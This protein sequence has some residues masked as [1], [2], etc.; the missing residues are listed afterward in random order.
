[1]FENKE[2]QEIKNAYNNQNQTG[3]YMIHLSYNCNLKCPYCYQSTIGKSDKEIDKD[4]IINFI[5]KSVMLENFKN[6]EICYI[7][8]EPL[9]YID[10]V[11]YI[12]KKINET[13]KDRNKSY[14]IITNGTLMNIQN[15]QLLSDIGFYNY[16]ITID[17][18]KE[19]HD[20]TRIN[21]NGG[22][23]DI[24]MK[25]LTNINKK[26]P[27]IEI[28]IN[29]NIS[30]YNYHKTSEMI[31]YIKDI[32]L[33]Y[34]IMFSMVF[35]NGTNESYELKEQNQIWKD[36]HIFAIKEG[37]EFEPFYRELYFGCALTQKNY[38][39]IS[40]NGELFK[41]INGIENHKYYLSK[42]EDFDTKNYYTKLL[43][44]SNY[45]INNK[46]CIECEFYPVCYGGCK[47]QNDKNG[48]KCSKDS[49]IEAEYEII[50]E[51]VNARSSGPI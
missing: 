29:C 11:E 45:E 42:M 14:S 19:H 50:K 25:N 34:P 40:P 2:M 10:E 41:C 31:K 32:N 22:T 4:R 37:Y 38:H 24:I 21:N 47:Y 48:F 6:L 5:K 16:Q 20:K 18:D 30:K 26:L 17:G 8:G 35:D 49:F 1:M 15:V 33:K 44:F 27:E 36:V 39:I 23:F 46:N 13:F 51:I 7:G 12:T 9:L 28:Y 43:K 3:H